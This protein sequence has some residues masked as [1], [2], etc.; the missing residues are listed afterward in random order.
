MNDKKKKKEFVI[1]E[2]DIVS[3][4]DDDIITLSG[5]GTLY[6]GG[7]DNKEKPF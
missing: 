7:D 6:W 5:V 3:F 1:P 2:A 4:A